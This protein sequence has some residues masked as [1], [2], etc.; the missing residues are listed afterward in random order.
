MRFFPVTKS[1]SKLTC[2][3]SNQILTLWPVS[4]IFGPSLTQALS[5]SVDGTETGL[6]KTEDSNKFPT[7]SRQEEILFHSLTEDGNSVCID[8]LLKALAKTGLRQNDPRLRE[9]MQNILRIQHTHDRSRFDLDRQAFRD[10]I[11]EN[12]SIIN[13][14]LRGQMVIPDFPDFQAEID[15]MY[16]KQKTNIKGKVA[17]YI[18]QLA[19]A[20]P[21][22]WGVSICTVDG[23]RH[24][25]GDVNVP[26]CLQSCSKP[27]TYAIAISDSTPEVVHRY[28]GQEPSGRSF[29]FLELDYKNQPHNPMINAGAIVTCSLVKPELNIADRFDYAMS[30]YKKL[31][32]GEFVGFNNAVFQSERVTA[33]RNF[34][35][36]YY[37]RE[38]KCFP[39]GTDLMETMDLYF[40]LCSVEVDCDSGA[41][42]AATLAN[43]G[44]NPLTGERVLN[45]V[46]VRNTLSLMH[47]CGMYDY[48]GQF[49]FRVGLPAK[50]G[51]AGSVLIVIP[52]VLGLCV[53]SPPLDEI[54]NSARGVAFCEELVSRFN[55][56]H[57]DNLIYSHKKKD[58][59]KNRKD[60]E[61]VRIFNLLFSAYNGELGAMKRFHLSGFNMELQ[62][63][64]GRTAL[65]L[66]AAE[67]HLP[68]AQYLLEIC[69]VSTSPKDRWGGTPLDEAERGGHED[70]AQLIRSHS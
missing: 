23:Q 63:Y 53:W 9:S 67:G 30:I 8:A 59:R 64:D 68:I 32:G 12:I 65:H 48:S 20:N 29:N 22:H 34:A 5:T 45:P 62:D 16:W 51:V 13:R 7:V 17:D 24:A 21:D 1:I 46:S 31:A 49:A 58:P 60:N 28:V 15:D 3:Q 19:R 57:Y 69:K 38:N 50:S 10:V 39:E 4:T 54:G 35:L 55:F 56:H 70:I 44:I 2:L 41:I 43:G 11:V 18:P 36:G 37:M 25:V 47:S 66:A 42:I 6:T 61:N 14:A 33:D 52:N 26:F 27:L 40:Q